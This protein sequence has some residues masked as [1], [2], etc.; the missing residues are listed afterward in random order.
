MSRRSTRRL[1]GVIAAAM[2]LPLL[3]TACFA[4][5]PADT[6]F[7][8]KIPAALEDAGF[9]LSDVWASRSTDGFA[10]VLNVGGTSASG[11]VSPQELREMLAVIKANNSLGGDRLDFSLRTADDSAFVDLDGPAQQ[12]GAK[13]R[14]SASDGPLGI[15]LDWE[16]VDAI[17]AD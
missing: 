5:P 1:V 8:D 14:V 10:V 16:A 17:I 13:P 15:D 11:E 6:S 2:T 7:E 12:L 4:L 9:G 3:V